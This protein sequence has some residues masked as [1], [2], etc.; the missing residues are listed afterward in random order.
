MLID[1]MNTLQDIVDIYEKED[2][3][4]LLKDKQVRAIK[5]IIEVLQ[6]KTD[7]D[8]ISIQ[9]AMALVDR[10]IVPTGDA[11]YDTAREDE[12]ASI[13]DDLAL[14][15]SAKSTGDLISIQMAIEHWG[16]SSGNLTND[17]IAELQREIESLP[18][19]EPNTGHWYIREHEYFTC[20][21]CGEDY[22]N[23]CDSTAEAEELLETG[24]YPNFCPNCGADMRGEEE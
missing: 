13:K 21:E 16:R 1:D 4:P 9:N 20:S 19:A 2:I 6:A 3:Y 10:P 11:V 24:D 7:G 17:Q 5:R 23:S 8:L 18:S 15:P 14:L 22:W 12:R